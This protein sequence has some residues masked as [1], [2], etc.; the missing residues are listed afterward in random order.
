MNIFFVAYWHTFERVRV[1]IFIYSCVNSLG[2]N[3]LL[4][5][6]RILKKVHF[7]F[8]KKEWRFHHFRR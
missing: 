3:T 2:K 1:E 5:L 7:F 6:K 8:D 4:F